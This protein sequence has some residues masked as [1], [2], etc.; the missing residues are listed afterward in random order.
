[1]ILMNPLRTA[2]VCGALM[3]VALGANAQTT[4][5]TGKPAATKMTPAARAQAQV[6]MTFRRW[7]TDKN[8]SLSSAEFNAGWAAMRRMV[9]VRQRLRQQ[10]AAVDA[11]KSGAIDAAEYGKLM[12][13]QKA[14][15]SAP[16][17]SAF[18][19]NKNQKLEF[20]EYVGL[21]TKLSA[22]RPAAAGTPP[23]PARK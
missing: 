5:A 21:V 18:D 12:L 19:T 2:A 20:A 1:M 11:D 22:R 3:V 13:V 9:E 8:G 17:L 15:A 4:T 7:D 14:G 6:D 10:F 23:A 16:A